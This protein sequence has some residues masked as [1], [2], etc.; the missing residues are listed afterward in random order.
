[1]TTITALPEPPSRADPTN[2]AARG[3]AFLGALPTFVTQVNQ[4]GAEVAAASGYAATAT[5]K[6][7]EASTSAATA[8]TQAGI[9]TTQASSAS[10]YATTASTKASEASTSAATATTK[11]S[12]AAASAT[13]ATTK[14]SEAAS[15]ATTAS[16]Q[17]TN[18]AASATTATNQATS[19]STS[20][21]TATTQATNASTSAGTAT[22]QA[23]IATTQASNAASSASAAAASASAA[24]A[25]YDAFDDRYLGS[26][27][28]NPTVDNDGNALLTGAMYFNSVSN[29]VKIF[30]GTTWVAFTL[31]SVTSTSYEVTTE[32][33]TASQ[34]TFTI[35][36]GYT[37]GK[38]D[39]YQNGVRLIPST[40]YTAVSGTTV[41]LTVGATLNDELM[42]VNFDAV[43]EQQSITVVGTWTTKTA[44]YTAAG[45]DWL[46]CNTIGG[47]FTITLP[48][49]PVIN[50]FVRIA[51]GPAASTNNVTVGRNG[52]TI[53]GLSENLTISDNN[54][55]VDFV[56]DGTTWRIA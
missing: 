38:I 28:S 18:A 21:S 27:A 10:T 36:G 42:F 7:S 37:P 5:T 55:S 53:M 56:Y 3:D 17:A 25:S 41:V 34:T 47:A 32:V 33:A 45:G 24:A 23:G 50:T 8:T 43:I 1:M 48:A 26:K 12:E 14:A 22:T 40:D 44:N 11:A 30:N 15:S 46:L 13:T 54:A 16:T 9:A 2:F 52:R 4:V 39:V 20:A 51:S 6:A 19:A 49:T 35:A 29:E 31:S